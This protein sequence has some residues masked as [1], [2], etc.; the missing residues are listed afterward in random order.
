[1]KL[2]NRLYSDFLSIKKSP[3]LKKSI[4][5]ILASGIGYGIVFIQNFSLAYFLSINFFGKISLMISLFST[6]YVLYT[7][8]LNAVVLRFFFD[9]NHGSDRKKFISHIVSLWLF[10]G[11]ILTIFFLIL[12]Y[13]CLVIEH[14]FQ[15][16]YAREFLLIVFAAFLFSFTEIFPNLFIVEEKPLHYAAYLILSRASTFI[17][18]HVGIYFFGESSFHISLM[19]LLSSLGLCVAGILVFNVFPIVSLKKKELKEILF[20]AFPL[21]IYALGGIGYSNGYRVIISNWLS[22]KEIAV[23]SLSSQIASVYYLAAS[24]SMTGL[25][26]KAYKRLEESQGQPQSI[27]FY[28]RTLIYVGLGLQLIILPAAY[29]FLLYF[30][31]GSFFPAFQIL[32]ILLLG[33]F[34]FFLYG[35]SYILCT[36]YKKTKVLT[37]S[38]FA[39]VATSLM[40]ANFFL[41][42][43]TLWGAALPIT[44]GLFVH[45][46]ISLIVIRRI[47]NK[48]L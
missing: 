29:V 7:F 34:I 40:L 39:G 25:Y 23:F 5:Y 17:L 45:F 12:G 30:K 4:I 22:Y 31:S 15:L 3:E 38:M 33:Q 46:L 20:Y 14:Y 27:R 6:L 35:Y 26:P 48:A 47:A 18:L 24:S 32:P 8:G 16:D 10:L 28:F 9:K 37:Y 13:E 2:Y 36:Y 43:N 19:L 44:C 42:K 21:M 41:S 1:M 11:G